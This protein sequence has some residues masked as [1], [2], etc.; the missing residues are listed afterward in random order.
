AHVLGAIRGLGFPAAVVAQ[1]GLEG[2]RVDALDWTAFDVLF[3]GGASRY[4]LTGGTY[5]PVGGGRARGERAHMRGR[6]TRRPLPPP[7]AA[8]SAPRG[9]AATIRWTGPS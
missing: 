2:V 3:I 6:H 7:P 9:S 1:D 4:K 8:A 5:A